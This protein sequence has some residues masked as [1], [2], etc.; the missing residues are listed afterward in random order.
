M[1]DALAGNGFSP[2]AGDRRPCWHCTWWAGF[3]A[4]GVHGRCARPGGTPVQA[5]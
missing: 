4:G 3:A 1:S 5:T 2:F